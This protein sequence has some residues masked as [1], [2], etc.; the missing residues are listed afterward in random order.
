MFRV[1]PVTARRPRGSLTKDEV[2]DAALA[3][4]DAD[5]VASLTMRGLAE[6][7]GVNPMTLYL[8]YDNKDALLAAMIARRL[9]DVRSADVGGTVEDRLVAWALAVRAQL[10]GLGNLLPLLQ[11]DPH[12]AATVLDS[13]DAG[14]AL[15]QDAGLTGA[16][17]VDA[18]RSLFWHTVGMAALGDS[19]HAH[20]PDLLATAT[21]SPDTHPHLVALATHFDEFDP[22]ALVERTTRALVHG[23]LATTDPRSSS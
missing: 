2:V 12:L 18:F 11:S 4:V 16:A 17:A 10:H 21:P 23:L 5:G 20:A 15:L 19:L 7:L 14:L 9:A 8:R 1:V 6:R 3:L 13:T 22:D